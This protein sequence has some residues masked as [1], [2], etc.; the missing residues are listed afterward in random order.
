MLSGF[1]IIS[2]L[3]P[4]LNMLQI[5]TF[6]YENE[7]IRINSHIF[8]VSKKLNHSL[9]EVSVLDRHRYDADPDPNHFDADPDPYRDPAIHVRILPQ[10]LHV[11]VNKNF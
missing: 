4:S 8:S 10:V 11:L 7:F 5:K 2:T 6:A 9:D 3:L 1:E